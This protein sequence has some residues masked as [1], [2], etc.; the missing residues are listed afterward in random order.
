MHSD[1]LFLLSVES[2]MVLGAV[3]PTCSPIPQEAE[4]ERALQV[5]SH[6][7]LQ[8]VPLLWDSKTTPGSLVR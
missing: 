6:P 8:S 7:G 4:V 2:Q 1:L 5:I 3:V